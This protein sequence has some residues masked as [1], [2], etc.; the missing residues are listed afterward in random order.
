MEEAKKR[1]QILEEH[2]YPRVVK[3]KQA[4]HQSLQDLGG[5]SENEE[6]LDYHC[7]RS[8]CGATQQY[9]HGG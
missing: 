6:H 5:G 3:T 8:S 7:R 1:R 2:P 9:L 4:G